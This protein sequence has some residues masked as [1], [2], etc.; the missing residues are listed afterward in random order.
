MNA[1]G[2]WTAVFDRVPELL[3]AHVQISFAALALGIALSVPLTIAAHR[4]RW[5]ASAILGFASFVQTIP[6]LALLALFFPLL[7]GLSTMLGDWV[8]PLGFLP[9]LLALT[10]YAL[11]PILRNALTGLAAVDPAALQ[12]ADGMGMTALQKLWLVELPLALPTIVAGI[13]TAAV[14]TIGAATLATTVGQ[15]SLGDLIFAGLQTQNWPLVLVGCGVSAALALSVDAAIGL[16]QWG[17]ENRWRWLAGTMLALV[18]L[19][20]AASLVPL[21][22]SQRDTIIIGAKG[23][24]EQYI[25]SRL[26]GRRLEAAGYAVDYRD[27]LGSAVVF[28]ALSNGDIDISVDY[29]GT[30]W[31]NE[32]KRSDTLPRP[33][34]LAAIGQWTEQ[35]SGARVLG[36]LGFENAYAFAVR[37][38][39]ARRY[40]LASLADLA[41][42]APQL[43]LGTDPEFLERPEWAS[44][45]TAYGIRFK[46]TRSLNPSF[47]YDALAT[48]QADVITAYTSDGRVA[49]DRLVVL[50]DPEQAIP[51]Y[52]ALLMVHRDR[53]DDAALIAAL[54]PLVGAIPVEAMRAANYSV[55]RTSDKASPAQAAAA[56]D[57]RITR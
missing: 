57:E 54:R 2:P 26:I 17:L 44:V 9:A 18:A 13:R 41:T 3:A 8:R 51:G 16:A 12:A 21:M 35:N 24:S 29:A 47:M 27:N 56:L 39:T 37:S 7:V 28:G 5:F 25:L 10:L 14:W 20:M 55:D 52:D 30:L 49:A 34:M 4:N 31:T 42:V 48:R 46:A 19:V 45:R 40:Q 1:F 38:E 36:G 22:H 15:P 53:L 6:S 23:F 43:T 50:S 33:A 32:M 11:L